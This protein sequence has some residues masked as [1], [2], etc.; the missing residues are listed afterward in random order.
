MPVLNSVIIG[1][2]VAFFMVMVS[3]VL[4]EPPA[5]VAVSEVLKVPLALGV[6]E[7]RPVLVFTLRPAGRPLTP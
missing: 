7:M 6:P 4:A 5:L 2:N 3:A 1:T